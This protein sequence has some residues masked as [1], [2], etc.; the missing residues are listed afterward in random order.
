MQTRLT[1]WSYG[2]NRETDIVMP[3]ETLL[4]TEANFRSCRSQHWSRD[5]ERQQTEECRPAYIDFYAA[6]GG[7]AE[8]RI[9]DGAQKRQPQAALSRWK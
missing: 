9:V 5:H 2:S 8:G 6:T 3:T 1:A 7:S 4:S